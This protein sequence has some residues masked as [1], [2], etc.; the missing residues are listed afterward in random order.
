MFTRTLILSAF[1]MISFQYTAAN[2]QEDLILPEIPSPKLE[3]YPIFGR[4]PSSGFNEF[5]YDPGNYHISSPPGSCNAQINCELASRTLVNYYPN[6]PESVAGY[7]NRW[8]TKVILVEAQCNPGFKCY[9]VEGTTALNQI[10]GVG[11]SD[12]DTCEEYYPLFSHPDSFV[13]S[14]NGFCSPDRQ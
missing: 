6:H 8:N 13:V 11:F 1:L 2:A 7:E 4:I 10:P 12:V 9:T 14:T 5:R 3:E